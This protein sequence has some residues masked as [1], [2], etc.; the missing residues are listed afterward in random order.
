M[1]LLLSLTVCLCAGPAY[2]RTDA[3]RFILGNDYLQRTIQI[4]DAHVST[5]EFENKLSGRT[6]SVE[7][8][9]FALELNWEPLDYEKGAENP[10][11]LNTTSFQVD[12][13]AVLD[14]ASGGKQ[15]IITLSNHDRKPAI[16]AR[17]IYEIL[18]NDRYTRQWLQIHTKGPGELF[19]NYAAPQSNIWPAVT[20]SLGGFGQ[21]VFSKD[22]FWGLEYPSGLNRIAGHEI[23]LGSY[24]GLNIPAEGFTTEKAVI[25]V[26]PPGEVQSAFFSYIDHIRAR[27]VRPY[28]LYNTWYDLQRL[29]M[30]G[31][32]TVER[33]H[34]LDAILQKKYNIKLDSF[35]L[36]DGWDNMQQLWRIDTIRFPGGFHNLTSALTGIGSGLGLWYGPVGGYDHRSIR[37][38]TGRRQG[39]EVESNGDYLCLAGRHYSRYFTDS[40]LDMQKT[41]GINYFKLDG[42]P[43]GCNEPDHGHP[44]GIYSREAD[45]RVFINLLSKLRQQKPD[46][47]LNVT[48]GI[49]LSPWW[50]QYADTVWMGGEDSGYLQTLPTLS[51]RQSAISYRDA[52][53]YNNF[54]RE[55]LQFPL[56][57][58]MT[59]GII[60]GK[61]N[62]LGG[63][64]E[65]LPDWKDELVH[66]ASVGNMMVELYITPELLNGPEWD[67]LA[68]T[69][70][71]AKANQ[72]PLLDNSKIV[73]GDPAHREPYGFVHYSP[74]NV[75]VTLRNP[76]A[77]PQTVRL[78]LDR[79]SG[80]ERTA[81]TY[82]LETVYPFRKTE[83]GTFTYGDTLS[84]EL[85]A[86]EERVLQLRP[87]QNAKQPLLVRGARYSVEETGNRG[88]VIHLYAPEG[89]KRS[90]TI[91]GI[92]AGPHTYE[93]QFG[94]A[95]QKQTSAFAVSTPNVNETPGKGT[96]L[97]VHFQIPPDYPQTTVAFL[98]E[99]ATPTSKMQA[100][101]TDNANALP[102]KT[103]NGG[104]DNWKWFSAT[105]TPGIHNLHFA[106]NLT[107]T[108]A[109]YGT[110]S[111]WA[112]AKR[113]L[114]EAN[115]HVNLGTNTVL[116]PQ[117][118]LLPV[119]NDTES[120]TVQ[121]LEQ[122]IR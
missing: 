108:T 118:D 26:A 94:N 75:I 114:A 101:L 67:A 36:D 107:G 3:N 4:T 103:E 100:T 10:W 33:V 32:N 84:V 82:R 112:I 21:P 57:S 39:M 89:A 7:G 122:T 115:I 87:T 105:L 29:A 40:L 83:T 85:G 53:L 62:L 30:N 120:T 80:F 48:T 41:Y 116:T 16:E 59:H 19:V 102:L 55:Q 34:Q 12:S 52:V 27:P 92:A 11:K 104:Q 6:Y 50:L 15:L 5:I 69:L 79:N 81:N 66:Y 37:I 28:V 9:E 113:H 91:T 54:V 61:Y 1:L 95:A 90:I 109:N 68:A 64:H 60:R 23:S 72:H 110:L 73:G 56:S 106:L 38:A 8:S 35:V 97:D 45:E 44:T 58:I 31:Q 22:L 14:L 13:H 47:F 76:F 119:S 77:R 86:F 71:W 74:E 93:T 17:L 49:W 88:A 111:G 20:P 24:V 63:A 65:S 96:T 99:P 43:F 78:P 98:F 18:P 70:H 25:G 51:P 46:V 121:F 42:V 2:V 117:S